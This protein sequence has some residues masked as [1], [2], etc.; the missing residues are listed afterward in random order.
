[1]Y[2]PTP[3]VYTTKKKK[4]EKAEGRPLIELLIKG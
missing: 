4:E 3:I 2:I 1:M